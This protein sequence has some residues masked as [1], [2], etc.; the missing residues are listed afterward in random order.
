MYTGDGTW[1]RTVRIKFPV[2]RLFALAENVGLTM[3][4]TFYSA[5]S[6]IYSTVQY[7]KCIFIVL[8]DVQYCTVLGLQQYRTVLYCSVKSVHSKR[9]VL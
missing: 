2:A 5:A 4:N 1:Y 3:S 6:T 9:P 7:S 8:H